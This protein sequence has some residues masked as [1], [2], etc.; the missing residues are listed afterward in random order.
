MPKN[1]FFT[2]LILLALHSNAQED[3]FQIDSLPYDA[4]INSTLGGK[5][6]KYFGK[7]D[8]TLSQAYFENWVSGGENA[9][10]GV[11]HLDY[12]FNYSNRKGWVWDN[13]M[14]ISLGGNKTSSSKILKKADDRFEI[15]SQLGKQINQFWN[16]AVYLSFKSQ[17]L[18]GFRYYTENGVEN[19]E[20]LTRLFSPTIMQFGVGWY[21]KKNV[22]SWVNLSPLSARGILVGA[23]FTRNLTEGQKY[24][25]VEKGKTTLLNLGGSINGFFKLSIM[26]NITIENKF[27]IYANYIEKIQNIDFEFNTILRMKVNR[28]ISSNLITHFL[29]DDDLMG[30]LQIREL[31]GAGLSIDL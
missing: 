30:R 9:F 31:F 7:L 22:N 26:N 16:Y 25:G 13:N 28:R 21:Y 15:N 6:M 3:R 1:I 18:P 10:N 24:F 29:Y 14:M 8:L 17:L 12:N 2:I 5:R 27:N 11:L 23:A 4:I 20:K 19:K